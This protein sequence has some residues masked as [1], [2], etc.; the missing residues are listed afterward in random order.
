VY[1]SPDR[2]AHILEKLGKSKAAAYV[3]EK[4]PKGNKPRS[5][6]LGEILATQYIDECT[7]YDVPIRRLRWKD[8]REMA[9]RGDD[10]I[11]IGSAEV[12]LPIRFIK[13][14][15][16]SRLALS[17]AVVLEARLALNDN[18]GLVRLSPDA[19]TRT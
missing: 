6:D 18:G 7:E 15:T 8:H 11:G 1:A 19:D 16:K 10:V 13:S 14:E 5:G 9:M 4:L 17:T 3:R 12:D 2:I